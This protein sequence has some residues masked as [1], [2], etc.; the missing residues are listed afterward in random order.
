MRVIGCAICIRF[1]ADADTIVLDLCDLGHLSEPKDVLAFRAEDIRI[2][3][4]GIRRY[5]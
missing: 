5:V 4:Q 1:H 3:A 2:K